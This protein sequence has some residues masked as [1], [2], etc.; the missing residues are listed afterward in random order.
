MRVYK[1]WKAKGDDD[2]FKMAHHLGSI[3]FCQ[4]VLM[5]L[6][7]GNASLTDRKSFGVHSSVLTVL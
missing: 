6:F 2:I 1:S 5:C 3:T 7:L 4:G